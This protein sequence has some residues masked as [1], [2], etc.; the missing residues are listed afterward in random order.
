[1]EATPSAKTMLEQAAA[2]FQAGD[3]PAAEKICHHVL[4]GEP[5]QA[6]ALHLLG[7]A[8]KAKGD[9]L[10]AIHYLAQAL[11][12][13]PAQAGVLF[14]LGAT[15]LLRERFGEAIHHFDRCLALDARHAEA[16]FHRGFA[17]SRL[18]QRK[19]ALKSLNL[20]ARH[21]PRHAGAHYNRG[22]IHQHEGQLERALARYDEAI[23]VQFDFPEAHG[24]RAFVLKELGDLPG[25]LES[26]GTAIALRPASALYHY[27]RALVLRR[28]GRAEAALASA[29]AAVQ[30]EPTHVGA[31]LE[32]GDLLEALKRPEEALKAFDAAVKA[33]KRCTPAVMAR[34]RLNLAT[35]RAAEA[36]ADFKAVLDE[37]PGDHQAA[38]GLIDAARKPVPHLI[39]ADVL[40]RAE[41]AQAAH[42]E[43]PHLHY[44]RAMLMTQLHRHEDTLRILDALHAIAPANEASLLA[45]GHANFELGRLETALQLFQQVIQ[46][47]P[48]SGAAH[49]NAGIVHLLFGD[50]GKGWPDY[51]WRWG[52]GVDKPAY[53]AGKKMWLGDEPLAGRTILLQQEQGLGDILQF[54]RYAIDLERLGAKVILSVPSAL[55][56]VLRSLPGAHQLV[57]G[58]QPPPPF[59]VYCPFL[60][61]PMALKTTVDT[62]PAHPGYLRAAPE[63]VSAWGARLGEHRKLR[64]G[65]VCS[66]N[67]V[68]GRD[69]LR[70]LPLDQLLAVL[71]P[72]AEGVLLQREIRDG[73][74]ELVRQTPSLRWFSDELRDFADTAALCAQM[75]V[76]VA[77]DTSIAHLSGAMGIPTWVLLPHVP[78]WRWLLEREDSPW[79]PTVRLFRQR[80]HQEGWGEVLRRIG[81]SL[82]QLS[83]SR[84]PADRGNAAS[85]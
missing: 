28:M 59:D 72:G 79:Y 20:A 21:N 38:M 68:H 19:E 25:A 56:R 40:R 44:G 17:L 53:T 54:S 37:R 41:A 1:M 4:Q 52:N 6:K 50:Y 70:S 43:S 76:V 69:S 36:V 77:V 57:P 42:P 29:R 18:G 64:V 5:G 13:E 31:L 62:I 71:P 58:E 39:D 2:L 3:T 61:L 47:N 15:E 30:F 82:A 55:I 65:I 27:S 10:G 26:Y 23:R 74:R 11:S 16:H 75:D 33:D 14:D 67:P 73:D 63:A 12:K 32:M 24:N 49:L 80:R 35:H 46:L 8:A 34:A 48:L 7:L 81:E 85:D 22:L 78:D 83:A 9:P 66:G 45:Q 51:E 84:P 60:S